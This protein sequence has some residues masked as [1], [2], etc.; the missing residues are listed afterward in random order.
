M[1]LVHVS[2]CPL[3]S[4][5]FDREEEAVALANATPYGLAG[6]SLSG[7]FPHWSVVVGTRQK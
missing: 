1:V 7:M 3:V 4:N 6:R 2:Q 5:R